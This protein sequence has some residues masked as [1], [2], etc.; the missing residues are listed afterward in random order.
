MRQITFRG[1]KLPARHDPKNP[2]LGKY[3]LTPLLAA[4]TEVS[5]G[6]K[7]ADWLMLGND[8]VGDCTCAAVAHGEMD[9]TSNAS[10]EFVPDTADVLSMYSA[11]TGYDPNAASD[12]DGNNPTDTGADM[13][14][15]CKYW[16]A[17]GL[18]GRKITAFSE[19]DIAN[20]NHIMLAVAL[21]GGVYL[22]VQLPQSAM[23]A[24]NSEQPWTDVMDQ[25]IVGGHAVWIVGY[26]ANGVTLVTWGQTVQATW[27][28]IA[29]YAD[30]A[31]A[32]AAP[33]WEEQSGISPS[34]INIQQMVADCQSLG[35]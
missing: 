19:I 18:C 20:Q 10:T 23:D 11:I 29:T 2:R 24:F 7:V 14:T 8:E 5:W 35:A 21:L 17:T 34:G 25:N 26:N 9:F 15:V 27:D 28:W 22:G 12:A 33:D 31:F 13:G 30:E 6:S 16:N 4:P 32:V 3:L 1:G